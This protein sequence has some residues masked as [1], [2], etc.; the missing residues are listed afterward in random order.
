STGIRAGEPGQGITDPDVTVNNVAISNEVQNATHGDVDNVTLSPMTV[1]MLDG[2]DTL[3]ASPTTT[4]TLIVNGGTG[5]DT[6][7]TRDGADT[8]NG[9]GGSDTVNAGGGND[10]VIGTADG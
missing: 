5:D 7:T 9:G 8:V 1:N 6:I 2:G 3:I 4:G 10:T